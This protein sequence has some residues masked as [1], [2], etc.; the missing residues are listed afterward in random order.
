MN[1][2]QSEESRIKDAPALR[3]GGWGWA[4]QGDGGMI[5]SQ[6]GGKPGGHHAT[7]T[8]VS[9]TPTL[10]QHYKQILIYFES[11]FHCSLIGCL[12]KG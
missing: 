8:S 2:V 3:V 7:E 6:A 1:E 5:A 12:I 11:I 9:T 4:G 10:V